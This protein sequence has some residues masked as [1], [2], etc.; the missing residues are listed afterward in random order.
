MRALIFVAAMAI[1]S[2]AQTLTTL[3]SFTAAAGTPAFM[4]KGVDGNFYAVGITDVPGGYDQV[5][6]KMTP[7]GGLTILYDFHSD[8]VTSMIQG[9]DG[10]FYGARYGGTSSTGVVYK[11]SVFELTPSG[12]MTTLFGFTGAN[13]ADPSS[14]IQASD[15]NFY[16]T[17]VRG[18]SSQSTA[19]Q[20]IGTIFQLTPQGSLTTLHSF[21][22]PDGANPQCCLIQGT[23]G[24]LYGPTLWGGAGNCTSVNS[25]IGCGTVFEMTLGGSFTMLH[26]FDPSEGVNPTVVLQATDGNLYGIGGAGLCSSGSAD[27]GTIY[28][29][30]PT[31][32]FTV[33]HSFSG[34]LADNVAGDL[35]QGSDGNFYG[36]NTGTGI[37]APY[38]VAPLFQMSP[39]GTLI[40]L[41]NFCSLPGCPDGK[42]PKGLFQLADG[43]LFGW[44]INGGANSIGT[45][46]EFSLPAPDTPAIASS[47][48]V[49]NG[50]SFQPGIGSDAWMTI[51]G[52]NLASKTDTWNNSIVN[53]ALPTTLDGVGVS[54][55]G[56]PAFIEYVSPTQINA[57]APGVP[58]GSVPV[59]VTNSNGTSAAATA[60]L[61][62]EQP[63]FFQWG[64]YAVATR[65][66]FSLAVKSG[67]FPGTT[68]VPA[69]PGDVIILWGTGFGPTSPAAPGGVE[70]PSTATYNTA[71]AVSVTVGGKPATV[72]GAALAPGYAGLY[73]VAIQIPASLANGDYPVVAT[74]SGVQS[75]ATTLITVQN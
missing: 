55:G 10:N 45:F 8:E 63:A 50:A 74:V 71:T 66:D 33:L 31:G 6:F 12:T 43:N 32:S 44:T 30:T 70:T 5:L 40:T 29:I 17:T 22:G 54:V 1:A 51:S 27:C 56:Q 69:K 21:T 65:Q 28:K 34:N 7:A 49:L 37:C 59:T 41:Y 68:T 24:N 23:D 75:P 53:G 42:L 38:C 4:F 14:L 57:I 2:Q 60:Q 20:G 16:G 18:G 62:A 48:G 3:A 67:T 11:G 64:T 15:G 61:S 26:S 52:T 35:I 46:F 19:S 25:S 73:Q 58:A 13:G 36:T 47:G 9:S 39:Q 72:Y